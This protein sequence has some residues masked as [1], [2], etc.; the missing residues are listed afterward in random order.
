[1]GRTVKILL[2]VIGVLMLA[3]SITI[4]AG[5]AYYSNKI[6]DLETEILDSKQAQRQK[7]ETEKDKVK[8]E[9]NQL[10]K[11]NEAFQNYIDSVSGRNE[12]QKLL[13]ELYGFN[14]K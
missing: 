5:V 8:E 11:E 3:S 4:G 9:L 7:I 13:A 10:K 12:L 2:V 1:M 14:A 6:E